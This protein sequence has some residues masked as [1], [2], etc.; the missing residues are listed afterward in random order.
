MP[1]DIP[2]T[3]TRVILPRRR[4]DLLSRQRLLDALF[5]LVDKKL[6]IIA[7]PAGYG[8]TSL[9]IDFASHIELPVCWYAIDPMDNDAQRFIAHF[10]SAI[11]VCF[12]QFGR[13][14]MAALKNTSQD[15]LDIDN[16][17]TTI[18]N[19]AYENISEHF[20]IVLDDYHLVDDSKPVNQFVNRFIQ[21]VDENCHMIVAS[22][23]LLTIPDLPLMVA[24]SQVGGLSFEELA[25]QID[26]VQ[27]LFF[28]NNLKLVSEEEAQELIQRTEGWITGILLTTQTI[29][30]ETTERWKLARIS[31]V[32][33]NE[34]F[35]CLLA[36]QSP[37][38]Q[39]FLMR[40]SLLE[41]FDADLCEAVIGKALGL[42][43]ENWAEKMDTVLRSN[44]FVLLVG[45]E[46]I[47]L[48]YHHLF[49]DYL[50]ARL[51][52]NQPDEARLILNRLAEVYTEKGD[53]ERAYLVY[54]RMGAS[55]ATAELVERAGPNLLAGGRLTTLSEWLEALPANLF[56]MRP[57][58]LS[59]QASVA[60]MR[61]ENRQGLQLFNQAI[62]AIT[63]PKD[64]V[65]LVRTLVRRAT[66]YR[67]I[68][69]YKSSL[70]DAEKALELIDNDS[71][72]NSIQ[73]EAQRTIGVCYFQLGRMT[74]AL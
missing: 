50:Q 27:E 31:G 65:L 39:N 30:G 34:Y 60:S 61:G 38:I 62:Q 9:L 55:G 6:T 71:E 8:K 5:N 20:A 64:R 57:A 72:L 51:F 29:A 48:R 19:D 17:I 32:G 3:R 26:E 69:D 54:Q 49:R 24:R 53:W 16:L 58:L 44:L 21:D 13:S 43:E 4:S 1:A 28:H 59:L 56:P 41:E 10:I 2:V 18:V 23:N 52:T 37:D 35:E 73:A 70:D 67:M 66:T 40:S 47:W 63:M 14:S 7:A 22:R 68:G 42:Q 46:G 15:H 74:D 45:D 12:P 11:A 36:P 25:F 33:I